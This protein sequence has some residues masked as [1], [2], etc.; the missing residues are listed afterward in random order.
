MTGVT[1]QHCCWDTCQISKRLENLKYH[2]HLFVKGWNWSHPGHYIYL[3]DHTLDVGHRM[4]MVNE[5]DHENP[6]SRSCVWSKVKVTFDLQ[7]SKVKVKPIGHI[8]GL[9]FN[10]YVCFSFRGNRTNLGWYIGNAIFDRWPHGKS[11]FYWFSKTFT[12]PHFFSTLES[13]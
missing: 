1:L 10:Q 4:A 13:P 6:W 7:N 11:K 3:V 2:S 8:W 9:K 12:G 5:F